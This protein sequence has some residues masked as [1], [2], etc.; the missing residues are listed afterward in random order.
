MR[1]TDKRVPPLLNGLIERA[2]PVAGTQAK[3]AND[4]SAE[5][6]N[7]ARTKLWALEKKFHCLIVGT[8]INADDLARLARRFGFSAAQRDDYGNHVEAVGWCGT[9]NNVSEALQRFLDKH[10]ANA[11]KRFS[12]ARNEAAILERWHDC[13]ARGEVA[14]PLW[15][16]VSHKH[17]GDEVRHTVYAAVHMLSHQVGA[18]QAADMRRLSLLEQDNVRLRRELA[19]ERAALAH[20]AAIDDQQ[21]LS[22]QAELAALRA[23]NTALGR[24]RKRLTDLENG[25][26][27]I[28]LGRRL[29]DLAE[30][31]RALRVSATRADALHARMEGLQ[32]ELAAVA[33]EHARLQHERGLLEKLL[34]EP[35]EEP[36]HAA[37]CGT[38]TACLRCD[39][40]DQQRQER[41]VLCVG[42]R[43]SLVSH[44]RTLAARLGMRLIHH[45]GGQEQALS[46]L[47]E[48]IASADAV[49]CPTDCVGHAAYYSLKQH[50]R[51][52]RKPCLL[53]KGAG[54]SSFAFALSR[55]SAGDAS[56]PVAEH[57]RFSV[58]QPASQVAHPASPTTPG[59]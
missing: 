14:G 25:S 54:V 12:S 53:F 15:A 17:A 11:L 33:A 6:R 7:I 2:V 18:G 48:M 27:M 40:T 44:Y 3:V 39:V 45:D 24:D 9:R 1:I 8:C 57:S 32:R 21:L 47:P 58:S 59:V 36:L 46:R 50:C 13:L 23:E 37:A 26:T 22:L 42:G 51:K 56:L 34:A 30:E 38:S 20:R 10:Y 31:N 55:L 49:L 19:T 28:A 5:A 16:A 52:S 35:P 41:C 4:S 29:M 43:T